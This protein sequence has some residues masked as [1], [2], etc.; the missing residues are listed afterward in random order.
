MDVTRD[1]YALVSQIRNAFTLRL[2]YSN[3]KYDSI[4]DQHPDIDRYLIIPYS[5]LRNSLVMRNQCPTLSRNHREEAKL[6]T[7][8][9]HSWRQQ[10]TENTVLS[11]FSAIRHILIEH[12]LTMADWYLIEPHIDVL[13]R[14]IE[15]CDCGRC[16]RVVRIDHDCL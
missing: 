9:D 8:R 13:T 12:K 7:K 1:L 2:S 15:W 16:E 5:S 6:V 14:R 11:L 10:D 4:R 3:V